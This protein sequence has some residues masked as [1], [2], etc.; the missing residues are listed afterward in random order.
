MEGRWFRHEFVSLRRWAYIPSQQEWRLRVGGGDPGGVSRKRPIH[1]AESAEEK[2]DGADGGGG[3]CVSG[4]RERQALYSRSRDV[5]GL[6]H[7]GK[8][9]GAY[10]GWDRTSLYNRRGVSVSDALG[11]AVYVT[12]IKSGV[13]RRQ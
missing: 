13:R 2:T 6:R 3:V 8:P 11:K 1:S 7:Q 12:E 9:L 10:P 5:V 4:H